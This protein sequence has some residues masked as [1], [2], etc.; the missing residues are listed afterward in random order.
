MSPPLKV[1]ESTWTFNITEPSNYYV[2]LQVP[3]QVLVN[4]NASVVGVYYNTTGL[5]SPS[6]CSEPLSVH[7]P[8]CEVH[9]CQKF[10]CNYI[11]SMYL[12]VDPTGNVTVNFDITSTNIDSNGHFAG[13]IVGL[14]LMFIFLLFVF[15]LVIIFLC[16][17]CRR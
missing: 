2:A 1:G 3:E 16:C 9:V 17:T 14:I 5:A 10:Y 6:D 4:S 7:H 12:L 11:P 8:S 13:F 15:V